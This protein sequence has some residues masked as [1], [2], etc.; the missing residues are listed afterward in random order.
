M[1]RARATLLATLAIF[2]Q[3]PQEQPIEYFNCFAV[4]VVVAIVVA[5]QLHKA[6]DNGLGM[7]CVWI[8]RSPGRPFLVELLAQ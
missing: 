1:R 8:G 2:G 6:Q 3:Q 5:L 4:V 7:D